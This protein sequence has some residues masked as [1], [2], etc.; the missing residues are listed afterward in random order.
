M[1]IMSFAIYNVIRTQEHNNLK[2]S[3]ILIV[4]NLF[5]VVAIR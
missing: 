2:D 3:K 5:M 1:G 4:T